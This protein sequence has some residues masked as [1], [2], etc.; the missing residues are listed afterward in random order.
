MSNDTR[1]RRFFGLLCAHH[2][3]IWGRVKQEYVSGTTR[4][5]MVLVCKHCGDM[6]YTSAPK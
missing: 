3:D 6:K 2:W 1:P 4:E 5:R